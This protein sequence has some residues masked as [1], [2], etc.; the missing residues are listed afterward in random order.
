MS[1]PFDKKIQYRDLK[2]YLGNPL[3]KRDNVQI[4]WTQELV[5]EYIKCSRDPFYFARQYMKVIHV[6]RGLVDLDLYP[7][8]VDMIASMHDHR[9]S[10]FN[11]ARQTGKTTAVTA[12]VLWYVLFQSDKTVAILANKGET[13]REI[14]GRIQLAYQHLPKWLQS[15]VVEWNKGSVTLENN[16]RIIA[17][18]TSSDAARGYSLN[19]VIIDEAA[20]IDNW[21]E[22]FTSVFPT[23]SS[24]SSTK[25]VLVSTVFGLNHF[26]K[27]W[28]HAIEG[29]NEYNP[30]QVRWDAVPGRDEKWKEGVLAAMGYDYER[31]AQEHECEFLGSSGTL[32]AGWKLKELTTRIPILQKGGVMQYQKPEPGR[33]YCIVADTSRGKGLDYSAFQVIDI[34]EMPYKQVATFRDNFTTPID[35][36]DTIY[37]MAKLYNDP[38]V[39]IEINDIGQE[40]ADH[41]YF[42][43]EYEN[44]LSTSNGGRSGKRIT[45]GF[46]GKSDRGI[47]TTKTVKA[48]G[49]SMVKLLIEQNQLIIQDYNTIQELS[50][51]S[52]KNASYEAEPGCHDDLVICLVLF[53]WLT[54]QPFFK[55]L[56]DADVLSKLRDQNES[57]IMADMIPFGIVHD[58]R[59]ELQED[60][61]EPV[62]IRHNY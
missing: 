26:Y 13:A 5:Q 40:V 42:H 48:I 22:F 18:A 14:L 20:H 9:Y 30:V 23:I 8:Q 17:T 45:G 34:T 6:D 54:V 44:V 12:F 32:I 1:D 35:F 21:D 3:L 24:G 19:C 39:L 58:G 25:V 28:T 57:Q 2:G 62:M 7:Y 37:R 10:I 61:W 27:I 52:K 29:K 53:A 56:F 16:S 11:C 47:R 38:P 55:D 41:V 60:G 50:T 36:A 43:Y 51:F 33:K 46:A 59:D 4:E 49:C 31:F 15:G